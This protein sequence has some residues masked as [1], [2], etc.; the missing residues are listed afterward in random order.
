MDTISEQHLKR[1]NDEDHGTKKKKQ[2]KKKKTDILPLLNFWFDALLQTSPDASL[3]REQLSNLIKNTL[4]N[5]P[6]ETVLSFLSSRS[7]SFS[8]QRKNI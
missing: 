1:K 8:F 4:P 6:E 7:K 2:K 5:F 3:S